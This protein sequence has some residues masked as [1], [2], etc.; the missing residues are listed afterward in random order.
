ML[1]LKQLTAILLLWVFVFSSTEFGQL[2][3]LPVLISHY[4]EHRHQNTQL[5]FGEFLFMHYAQGNIF[6][7]DF[8]TDMKLPFKTSGNALHN[9]PATDI[10]CLAIQLKTPFFAGQVSHAIRNDSNHLPPCQASVWQPP[11]NC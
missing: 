10:I 3:K 9:A 8:G 7:S 5:T 1:C 4:T 2:L 6:D 11:K